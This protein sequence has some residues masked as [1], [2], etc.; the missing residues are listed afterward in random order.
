[1]ATIVCEYPALS[2]RDTTFILGI[3]NIR[4]LLRSLPDS[5][6]PGL[7]RYNRKPYQA[8]AYIVAQ[9]IEKVN[10]FYVYFGILAKISMNTRDRQLLDSLND[11]CFYTYNRLL[12]VRFLRKFFG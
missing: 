5:K 3:S 12:T 7:Y 10:S 4:K 1:M 6:N 2:N 9:V 8:Y 11:K